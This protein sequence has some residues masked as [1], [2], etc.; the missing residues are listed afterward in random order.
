MKKFLLFV[1]L[2]AIAGAC[3]PSV[4]PD[5]HEVPSPKPKPEP[6]P[7]PKPEPEPEPQKELTL[8]FTAPYLDLYPGETAQLDCKPGGSAYDPAKDYKIQ[9]KSSN[10]AVAT[11]DGSGK[12]TAKEA[13]C[14]IITATEADSGVTAERKIWVVNLSQI[15]RAYSA[16]LQFT[17]G[18]TLY[19]KSVVQSWDFFDD[20]LYA[21]QVCG[22]PH[23]LTYTREPVHDQDPQAYMHLKYFGH[24]DNMFVERG[25][26]GDW[27]WT[28]NYGTLEAG[29]T[30]RYTDSQVLS[31]V[32]FSAGVTLIPSQATDNYVMPGMKR[33]IAAYD[34][35]NGTVGIWCRESNGTAR[36]Y[37]Y[38]IETLKAAPKEVITLSYTISYGSPVVNERPTVRACN[39]AK[40]APLYSFKMPFNNVPQGYDWHHGKIWFLR[41]AA[42]E[43]E[44]VAAGTGK[45]WATAY[46]I[47]CTGKKLTTASVPWVDDLGLLAAQGLTDLGYFETEGIKIKDGVLYLG[48]AS[49]D[50]GNSPARR[51]NIFQ[52][53]LDEK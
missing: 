17:C 14:A 37:V 18:H 44:D 29:Q 48:F 31:R 27:L 30:N 33:L 21:C 4:E 15:K 12:V 2:L 38:D 34:P 22:S 24:G 7:E 52:Y 49:R 35:D 25:P 40:L 50:A 6:E 42:A 39:L 13:G 45:N 46:L 26:D 32:R 8:S 41:G 16:S 28:S 3:G 20:Y 10:S 47:D 53:S 43:A 23:T 5:P 51:V 11:V 36:F 1:S 9:Y 19:Y